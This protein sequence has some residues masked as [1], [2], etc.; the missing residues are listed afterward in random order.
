MDV[1][2]NPYPLKGYMAEIYLAKRGLTNVINMWF[3]SAKASGSWE[4]AKKT[5]V[6]VRLAG[7]IKF[8]FNQPYF[9]QRLLGY[10][11]F[12]IQG[13]EYY[14]IDGVAGGSS[15]QQWQ[16]DQQDEEKHKRC[17]RLNAG[18]GKR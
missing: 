14:V 2:Y 1:D 13:Y 17:D 15:G 7:A 18:N 8:P 11:D 5:Y 3:L 9:N 16:A 10:S 6:G 12:F 4:V